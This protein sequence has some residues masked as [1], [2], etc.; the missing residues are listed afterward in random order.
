MKC[1]FFSCVSS[2]GKTDWP[3]ALPLLLLLLP[4]NGPYVKWIWHPSGNL[5]GVG[6]WEPCCPGT[7][8]FRLRKWEFW[9]WQV[10][11]RIEKKMWE[12]WIYFS[13]VAV[14]QPIL[15]KRK[16][17][18]VLQLWGTNRGFPIL[19]GI[20]SHV[21]KGSI[22]KIYFFVC[23]EENVWYS[24]FQNIALDLNYVAEKPTIARS[25][26]EKITSNCGKL[27]WLQLMVI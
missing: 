6:L 4:S 1:V 12:N 8:I 14:L 20:D 7:G 16:K 23:H 2:S 25:E 18:R 26:E 11:G 13:L 15:L 22:G 9:L 24:P 10:S 21:A 17:K 19:R 5:C 27:Q 3:L